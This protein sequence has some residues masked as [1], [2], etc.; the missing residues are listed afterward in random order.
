MKAGDWWYVR[1]VNRKKCDG[2]NCKF[3]I[4]RQCLVVIGDF[5]YGIIIII[6]I[7]LLLNYY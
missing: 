3:I 2:A 5:S 4:P 6:T 7:K 1:M